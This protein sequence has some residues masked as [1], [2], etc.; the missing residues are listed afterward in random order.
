VVKKGSV[1]SILR[2]LTKHGGAN[3]VAVKLSKCATGSLFSPPCEELA[4]LLVSYSLQWWDSAIGRQNGSGLL[5][6]P[7]LHHDLRSLIDPPVQIISGSTQHH[8]RG[9]NMNSRKCVF[10][11]KLTWL[12]ARYPSDLKSTRYALS[13]VNV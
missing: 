10:G 12:A 3:A 4:G 5:H 11:K 2:V 9:D 8:N 7:L 6:K 13:V 1:V